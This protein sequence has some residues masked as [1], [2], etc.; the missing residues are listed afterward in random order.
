LTKPLDQH[1]FVRSIDD[2]KRAMDAAGATLDDA[3]LDQHFMKP[4]PPPTVP[5][6]SMHDSLPD[7]Y[8]TMTAAEVAEL[9]DDDDRWRV[10]M[11]QRIDNIILKRV[12]EFLKDKADQPKE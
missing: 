4:P 11:C 10:R 7:G 6:R 12:R 2:L 3:P 1:F 5:S 9:P 8:L